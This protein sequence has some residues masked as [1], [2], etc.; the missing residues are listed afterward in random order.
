MVLRKLAL[1]SI[2]NFG[3]CY[4]YTVSQALSLNKHHYLIWVYYNCS[5]ISFNDEILMILD[6][7]KERQIKKPGV[8]RSYYEEHSLEFS[9]DY[10]QNTSKL[11]QKTA[12]YH[13]KK[14]IGKTNS[15]ESNLNNLNRQRGINQGFNKNKR[16]YY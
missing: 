5:H 6:I 11:R 12:S 13:R 1:K 8:H 15:T 3:K 16:P 10:D 9:P 2:F 7:T 4:D 14:Y